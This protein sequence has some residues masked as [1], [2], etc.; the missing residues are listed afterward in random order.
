MLIATLFGLSSSVGLTL[1]IVPQSAQRILDA[2]GSSF[3]SCRLP[4]CQPTQYGYRLRSAPENTP[5]LEESRSKST[6]ESSS[7]TTS[8]VIFADG[9]HDTRG[10]TPELSQ[11]G[12]PNHPPCN[13]A[14]PKRQCESDYCGVERIDWP[15]NPARVVAEA[16]A[17]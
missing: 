11:V 7:E 14:S 1:R 6:W 4:I 9:S 8:A 17:K 5:S 10:F 2:C 12:L 3:P 15:R 13:S 16:P